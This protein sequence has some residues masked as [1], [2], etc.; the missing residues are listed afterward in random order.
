MTRKSA[1]IGATAIAI[2]LTGF[3]LRPVAAAPQ[4]G[5]AVVK[6]NAGAD[7]FSAQRKRR[8]GGNP[9]IPLAAF[10]ALVGTIAT[11]AAA[12]RQREYYDHRYHAPRAYYGGP[13]YGYYDAPPAYHYHQPRVYHQAPV[14]QGWRGGGHPGYRGGPN[15]PGPTNYGQAAGQNGQAP[16]TVPIP[17]TP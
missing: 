10:G 17:Q 11:V 12:N 5:P 1:L 14:H 13:A 15:V 16:P 9:A 6:Q 7:E 3:D 8:R 4:G 2:A